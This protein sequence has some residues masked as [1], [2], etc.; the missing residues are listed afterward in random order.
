MQHEVMEAYEARIARLNATAT[1][2]T[3]TYSDSTGN[4]GGSNQDAKMSAKA[5][6]MDL[7]K[8]LAAMRADHDSIVAELKP[9]VAQLP[10]NFREIIRLRD[11][12]GHSWPEVAADMGY[13]DRWCQRIQQMAY[14]RLGNKTM[15]VHMKAVY[16]SVS[17]RA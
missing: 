16:S 15:D 17:S 7:E 4:A 12:E 6:A 8:E 9:I 11:L 5:A 1:R 13:T 3:P 2:T 14:R 10:L